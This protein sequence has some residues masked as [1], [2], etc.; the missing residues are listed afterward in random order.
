MNR[1]KICVVTG[2]RAEYGLLYWLMKEIESDES[3]ELQIAVTG[4][5]LSPEFGLTYKLIEQDGFTIHEKIEMLLSSDTPVGIATS[6]GLGTIGF[7]SAFDRLKPDIVVVL[8]DRFETM[9]ATQAAMIARIPIAHLYGGEITEGVIDEAIRHSITKMAH[10]HFVSTD[11]YRKRVIQLG[12]HPE[13]VFNVG[14][15]G[16]DNIRKMKLLTKTEFEN[17]IDFTLGELNFLVTYHPV[18]LDRSG[19]EETMLELFAALDH[20]PN[21]KIIFTKPN[22]DTD[23]RIISKMIDEYVSVNQNRSISFTSLGQLRYLSAIQH[24]DLVIGN[25][26]SGII[27]VPSFKKATINLGNRQRGRLRTDSIIDCEE[28]RS[29]IINAI[30]K[31]IS[32]EFQQELQNLRSPYGEEYV[33]LKILEILKNVDY[34]DSLM[35]PF[36]DLGT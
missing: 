26:S 14:A 23:G 2:T 19:P 11:S 15:I 32:I 30:Q 1:R 3:F 35:K 5:H 4:M 22:S 8:G 13:R 33:S 10:Y 12:E 9:A 25:S 16:L 36:C 20:F 21:A 27:E 34:K 7:A 29:S 31:G 6:L 24:V 28:Q 17:S 18:T